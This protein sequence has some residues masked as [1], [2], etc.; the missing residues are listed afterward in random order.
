MVEKLGQV[1]TLARKCRGSGVHF[2]ADGGK[3][4]SVLLVP[5]ENSLDFGQ[6]LCS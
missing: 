1:R 2:V 5:C 6:R 3:E 4:V